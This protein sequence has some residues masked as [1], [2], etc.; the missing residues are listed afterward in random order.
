MTLMKVGNRI[1]NLDNLC[2]ADFRPALD[3]A[4]SYLYLTYTGATDPEWVKGHEAHNW[5]IALHQ[6]LHCDRCQR[7]RSCAPAHTNG[8]SGLSPTDVEAACETVAQDDL[9][10][11]AHD[12]NPNGSPDWSEDD[13]IGLEPACVPGLTL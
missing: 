3:P 11:A 6:L 7:D 12:W 13:R 5:W 9:D 1:V 10:Q 2:E 4:Q 8:Q